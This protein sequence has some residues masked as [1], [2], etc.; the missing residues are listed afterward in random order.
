MWPAEGAVAQQIVGMVARAGIIWMASDEEVLARSLDQT[1][2]ARNSQEVVQ[3]ADTLYRPYIVSS[4]DDQMY[5][6]FRDKVISDKVGFTYSGM[7]GAE[8]AADFLQRL[9]FQVRWARF[10]RKHLL[11]IGLNILARLV[12]ECGQD[13]VFDHCLDVF[14]HHHIPLSK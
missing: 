10:S 8:A 1:A 12:R 3:E 7:D 14:H 4:R 13:E 5:I 2:F 6:I 11:Q 9:H